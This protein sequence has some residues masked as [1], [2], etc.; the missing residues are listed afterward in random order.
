M[1]TRINTVAWD[2][3]WYL[4]GFT[5]AEQPFGCKANAEGSLYLNTQ[6]WAIMAGI[7]DA[8]RQ[9]KLLAS[10]DQKLDGPHGL[11]LFAPAYTKWDPSLGRIS[12]F[13]EGTKENA[14]VFCHATTF[15]IVADL[16]AGRGTIAHQRMRAIMPNSQAD[17]ELYKTEPYAFA[18]YLVGPDNPYRYGEGAFTWI[19]GTAGWYL[20]A[21]TEWL[22]GV[23]RDYQ[24]LRIDP[25]L[26]KAW[27]RARVIRPFRGAVYDIEIL[28]PHGLEK[29]RASVTVDGASIEGNLIT[30]HQDGRT[31]KVRVTLERAGSKSAAGGSP[32]AA[33]GKS[34]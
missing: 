31:H 19:T 28:N 8:A 18:E 15:M 11:A 1:A 24:G 32:V 3:D 12:M 13:S 34:V 27:K 26:P 23:R 4:Y 25:C 30:P 5:D 16:M 14:A 6:S 22:L 17:Y 7:A 2:G 29:G 10:V 9:Q 20:M 21:A 33:V